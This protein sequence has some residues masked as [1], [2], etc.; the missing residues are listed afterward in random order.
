MQ[1]NLEEFSF[2]DEMQ[3]ILN[4]AGQILASWPEKLALGAAMSSLFSFFN[5]DILLYYVFLA[6][7]CTD[8]FLGVLIG[9]RIEHH[10]D[11][12]KVSKG[13]KKL[14]AFNLYIFL[15]GVASLT[16]M[17]MGLGSVAP[18]FVN[19]F[20]GYLIFHEIISIIRNMEILGF[21]TPPLLKGFVKRATKKIERTVNEDEEEVNNEAGQDQKSEYQRGRNLR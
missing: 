5:A 16:I 17:R 9:F 21:A 7:V 2:G 6:L 12:H 10:V 3:N 14:V 19:L 4:T 8:F 11:L 20:I 1:K 18:M 13:I 15:S